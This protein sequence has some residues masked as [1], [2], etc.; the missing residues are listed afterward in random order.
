[1]N[2]EMTDNRAASVWT[3]TLNV[4][5]GIWLIIAPFLLLYRNSTARINDIVVG[6]VIVVFALIR[7]IAPGAGTA[8]LSWL[9]TLC[10]L[11]L[12]VASFALGYAGVARP[13]EVILGIIVVIFGL[14]SAVSAGRAGP[15]TPLAR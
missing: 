7:A 8:W 9:N 3:S 6:A 15:S 10:G 2:A 13:N 12:I 4:V 1:M 11:W 5:A 14:W